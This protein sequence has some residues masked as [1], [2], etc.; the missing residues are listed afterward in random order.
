[1]IRLVRRG[2]EVPA[3]IAVE[4]GVLVGRVRGI[5][6]DLDDIWLRR[7]REIDQAEYDYQ[8]SL[9]T[10]A[11]EHEPEGPHANP[12]KPIDLHRMKPVF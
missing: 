4:S 12:D 2:I 11:D 3:R 10:W 7:G 8:M 9:A 6:V 5:V 1:M